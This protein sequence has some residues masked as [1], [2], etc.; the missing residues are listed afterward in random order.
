[1][2][3]FNKQFIPPLIDLC[4]QYLGYKLKDLSKT[5]EILDYINENKIENDFSFKQILHSQANFRL[6]QKIYPEFQ[7]DKDIKHVIICS[8]IIQNNFHYLDDY[9][10]QDNT[11]RTKDE[12]IKQFN[13]YYENT[14]YFKIRYISKNGHICE[15]KLNNNDFIYVATRLSCVITFHFSYLKLQYLYNKWT[16]ISEEC[17][18]FDPHVDIFKNQDMNQLKLLMK[19]ITTK[20]RL[21]FINNP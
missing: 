17:Y 21:S 8:F 5:E 4:E 15:Q 11:H 10:D 9:L 2:E 13:N 20:F 16:K 1:M 7:I 3:I 6:L 14:F 18:R 19:Y 12:L